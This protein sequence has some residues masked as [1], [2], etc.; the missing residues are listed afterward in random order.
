MQDVAQ[1]C[2]RKAMG[3]FESS[4]EGSVFVAQQG[5]ADFGAHR[6]FG[7]MAESFDESW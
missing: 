1:L 3:K 2:G 6:P 5:H 4:S 7:M